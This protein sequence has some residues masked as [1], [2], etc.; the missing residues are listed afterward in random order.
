MIRC[1]WFCWGSCALLLLHRCPEDLGEEEQ[2]RRRAVARSVRLRYSCSAKGG[3][4]AAGLVGARRSAAP[5]GRRSTMQR[6]GGAPGGVV[7]SVAGLS[8]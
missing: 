2:M 3:M 8:L 7:S 5:T 6:R 1:E 4:H